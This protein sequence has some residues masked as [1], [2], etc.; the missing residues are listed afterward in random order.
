LGSTKGFQSFSYTEL[1]DFN[2]IR[3]FKAQIDTALAADDF[4]LVASLGVKLQTLQQESAQLSLSEEDYL[5]LPARHGD[6]VQRMTGK[7]RELAKAQHFAALGTLS[8][9][10]KALRALDVSIALDD[11]ENDPVIVTREISSALGT[12]SD[13]GENDPMIVTRVA[14]SAPGPAPVDHAVWD[15]AMM[16]GSEKAPVSTP[17]VAASAKR[18]REWSAG[19]KAEPIVLDEEWEESAAGVKDEDA[20]DECD[21]AKRR[22]TS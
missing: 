8:A 20:V 16:T 6:L 19:T 13:D 22:R 7:C 21:G 12:V 11:G 3:Y 15:R 5:T 2:G 10:L 17:I 4:E 1:S 9:K 18:A 14:G